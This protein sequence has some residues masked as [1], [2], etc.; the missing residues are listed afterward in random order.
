[1]SGAGRPKTAHCKP[2]R[3]A[4]PASAQA[5]GYTNERAPAAGRYGGNEYG[6]PTRRCPQADSRRARHGVLGQPAISVHPRHH[7]LSTASAVTC[8]IHV[9]HAAAT[10][11]RFKYLIATADRPHG[12]VRPPHAI[13]RDP[14]SAAAARSPGSEWRE[15]A[16]PIRDRVRGIDPTDNRSL[17]STRRG[18][19]DREVPWRW[20]SGAARCPRAE[21]HRA[22]HI[23][24][25]SSAAAPGSSR[26]RR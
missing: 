7:P 25:N 24:K 23:L 20:P 10:N 9:W 3:G 15:T 19:L 4:A 8:A 17:T 18:D 13:G 1:M 22:K 14:T 12:R 2:P 11:A 6:T 5:W 16:A 21:R 26:S